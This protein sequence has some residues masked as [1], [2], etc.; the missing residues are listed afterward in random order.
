MIIL[1]D[2]NPNVTTKSVSHHHR[3]SPS[4]QSDL[5]TAGAADPLT[6]SSNIVSINIMMNQNVKFDP[7][8]PNN[9]SS[10]NKDSSSEDEHDHLQQHL[11]QQHHQ[12]SEKKNGSGGPIRLRKTRRDRDRRRKHN[13]SHATDHGRCQVKSLHHVNNPA[14]MGNGNNKDIPKNTEDNVTDATNAAAQ[15]DKNRVEGDDVSKVCP[16]EN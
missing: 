9:P 7:D 5:N 1:E 16:P 2:W 10:S 11:Q 13:N 14:V 6:N 4:S 15:D 12:S 3:H 8:N